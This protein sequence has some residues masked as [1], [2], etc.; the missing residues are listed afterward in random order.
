MAAV[1]RPRF[2]LLIVLALVAFVV[3]GFA[4]SYYLRI[5]TAPPPLT[6]LLHVHAVVFTLWMA[7][8][9]GQVG[10][11][12]AH[13][14]DLHRKLGI[15]S[16]VF[17]GIVVTVGVLSVFKTAISNHVS[18]SG[19]APP[20]FSIIGFTSIGLF[21]VFIA[22]GIAYRRRPALHRR[23]M[24]LGFI[25]SI[26]PATARILR[27]VDLQPHRDLLIPLCAGLFVAA[28]LVHD[29]RRHRVV[30]P[31]Y[32][33]GGIAIIASWPVRLMIGRSDWYFPIGE[34]VARLARTMFGS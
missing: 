22:L 10:L 34:Q 12:A 32:V 21:A 27:M 15:A 11:V 25:A 8:F 24:I 14:V 26:S 33:V 13:R 16:A 17:A 4:P 2:H 29:W 1:R 5:L 18:P 19:L 20:Q 6:T 28:C 23:F 3:V 9:L 7:L 30:H 31:V